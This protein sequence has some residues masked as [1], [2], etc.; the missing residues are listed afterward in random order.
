M[1]PCGSDIALKKLRISPG[2]I[3]K[4]VGLETERAYYRVDRK[5]ISY[6][7]FI[8]EAYDGIAALTTIDPAA[9]LICFLIPPGC[10][11]EVEAVL[12]DLRKQFRID[13][14]LPPGF[15]PDFFS[16]R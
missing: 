1:E 2:A 6:L 4:A 11:R 13:P 8:F 7:R 9:G 14:A 5:E 12:R 16:V 3:S 15:V 10:G